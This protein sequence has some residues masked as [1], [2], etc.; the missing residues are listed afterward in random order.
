[1]PVLEHV[2]AAIFNFVAFPQYTS[3]DS[4][5]KHSQ[6][7]HDKADPKSCP[8]PTT[9]RTKSASGTFNSA[10]RSKMEAVK[11]RSRV[12]SLSL[13]M[14]PLVS[15]P[16]IQTPPRQEASGSQR[17]QTNLDPR[18]PSSSRV[19]PVAAESGSTGCINSK[20]K[21]QAKGWATWAHQADVVG[22][23]TTEDLTKLVATGASPLPNA[24][25]TGQG[26]EKKKGVKRKRSNSSVASI[27][28]SFTPLSKKLSGLMARTPKKAKTM[29]NGLSQASNTVQIP[30]RDPTIARSDIHAALRENGCR[31]VG[32]SVDVDGQ[33]CGSSFM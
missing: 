32:S 9:R 30:P 3:I 10:K 18:L 1:M 7:T 5:I 13:P 17:E 14:P 27:S 25:A 20:E 31:L 11:R 2:F 29:G 24:T 21:G 12:F 26:E 23:T 33:S 15:G 22:A 28:S 4:T 19:H 6:P 16:P 8:S